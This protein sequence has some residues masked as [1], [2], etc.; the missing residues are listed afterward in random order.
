MSEPM[1]ELARE[2]APFL[3]FA[4]LL[5]HASFTVAPEQTMAWLAA[6]E[7]LGPKGIGDIR[8]AARATLAPPPE[9]FEEFDAL[10]DAHFLGAVTPA[11]QAEPS[12]DEAPPAADDSAE[13]L[14][15]IYGDDMH[16]SGAKA[17]AASSP[18]TRKIRCSS[19]PAPCRRAHRVGKAIGGE[20]HAVDR[21]SM[22]DACFARQ[23]VTPANSCGCTEG[24]G[25][26]A[27]GASWC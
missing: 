17:T 8:R 1:L 11:L 5:R 25:G 6:I 22:R 26:C 19:S 14:E 24:G 20:G 27:N 16:E 9:R 3:G 12:E 13:G 4:A 23:C 2:I 15:P 21:A 18:A 10:F 7:L